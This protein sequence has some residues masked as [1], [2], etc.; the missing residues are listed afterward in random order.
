[1]HKTLKQHDLTYMYGE[2][3][4]KLICNTVDHRQFFKTYTSQSGKYHW[5]NKIFNTDKRFQRLATETGTKLKLNE[6][7]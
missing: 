3:L 1:M 6:V 5:N 4:E 7:P 2:D